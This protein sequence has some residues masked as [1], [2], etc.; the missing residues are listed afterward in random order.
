MTIND[1]FALG[2]IQAAMEFGI[3]IPQQ[4][5]LIG[6]DDVAFAALPK[7]QLTTLAQPKEE[8]CALAVE[9]LMKLIGQSGRNIYS[10]VIQ[11]VLIRRETCVPPQQK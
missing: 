9:T 3:D 11:P 10:E 5:S 2:I 4:V 1:H 7:I 6:F 8:L